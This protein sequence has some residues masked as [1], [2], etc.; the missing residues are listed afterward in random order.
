MIATQQIAG[1]DSGPFLRTPKIVV[2]H[3]TRSGQDWT[4]AEELG[5]TLNWFVN[6]NGASSHWVLSELERVRVVQDILIAWHSTYLNGRA[7]GIEMTQPTID[8]DFTDGH[9]ANAALIGQNYVSLGVAPVWL[10]YWD[11]GDGSGFVA[12]EDTKQGRESGK[13]D[14]GPK[15]DRARFISSLE[16]KSEPIEEDD[17]PVLIN[18]ASDGTHY[19]TDWMTRWPVSAVVL[20]QLRS[21]NVFEGGSVDTVPEELMAA[22]PLGH[23]PGGGSG[24]TAAE[25]ADELARRLVE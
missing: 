25:V 21:R 3:A 8:R 4:D 17:M 23:G 14:P 9:Y 16:D 7:W 22:I 24:A 12:H 13:S 18:T 5:A 20:E 10:D 19:L 1:N 6:P 11:G 2:M 15:F